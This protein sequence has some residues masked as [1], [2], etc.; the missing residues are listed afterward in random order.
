M[1]DYK[2]M[3]LMLAGAIANA[4]DRFS[5][6]GNGDSKDG[7]IAMLKHALISAEDIYINTADGGCMDE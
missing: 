2:T 4:L 7:M 1:P 6:D 3:Y 5:G